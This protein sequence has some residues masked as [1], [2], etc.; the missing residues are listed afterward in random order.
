MSSG[1]PLRYAQMAGENILGISDSLLG[2]L[3]K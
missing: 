1:F 2:D 3:S